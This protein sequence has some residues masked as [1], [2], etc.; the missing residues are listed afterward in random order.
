MSYDEHEN[1]KQL[2]SFHVVAIRGKGVWIADE[3]GN[4]WH[5]GGSFDGSQESNRLAAAYR[6]EFE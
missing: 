6:D 5:V 2:D 4:C 1:V 3:G